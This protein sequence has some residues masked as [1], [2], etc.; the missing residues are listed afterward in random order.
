MNCR[1]GILGFG[2]FGAALAD[3]A[4]EGGCEVRAWDPAAELPAAL[5]A[6]SEA[7]LAGWA[8][9]IVLAVP[10]HRVRAAIEPWAGLLRPGQLV[11]HVCSVQAGPSADLA[12]V[13]GERVPWIGSHPLFGPS[14][15]ARG[16]RP[17]RTV[18]CLNPAHPEADERARRFWERLGCEVQVEEAEIHDRSMAYSHALA[19]F[20]AKGLLDLGEL[21]RLAFTP[22]SFQAMSRTVDSVRSD[23]GHLFLA[24]ER[25]NPFAAEARQKLLEAL[26]EVHQQLER[27]EP[28]QVDASAALFSIPALGERAPELKQTRELIDE[29]DVELVELLARRALLAKRAGSI[30]AE[31]GH[32][33]RDP[34][35]EQAVL[36]RRREWAERQGLDPDGVSRVFE[37]VMRFSRDVQAETGSDIDC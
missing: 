29:L 13:L 26:A 31:H 28:E 23:A 27:V 14:A 24:I 3:L 34:G 8:E 17:L 6:G 16:E 20:V 5:A 22:P 30:K 25:A 32:G 10:V 11:M 2:R 4:R 1:L 18:V 37:A 35:R 36:E 9:V 7:E 12:E 19:F 21:D 33:V 15:L